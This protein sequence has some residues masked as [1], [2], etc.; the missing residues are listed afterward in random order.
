MRCLHSRYKPDRAMHFLLSFLITLSAFAQPVR[1]QVIPAESEVTYR[2]V[3]FT[4]AWSG[5]S[6]QLSGEV[7]FDPARPEASRVTLSAPVASFNSG[8]RTRDANM[9][10]LFRA[11]EHPNVRFTSERVEVVRWEASPSGG[12]EGQWRVSGMLSIAG[13]ALPHSTLVDVQFRD[14]RFTAQTAFTFS[15]DA[16]AIERPRLLFRAMEDAV[17]M[18]VR[19]TASR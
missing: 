12:M 13:R 3:H 18:N 1:V 4:H 17:Q 9:V 11:S 16:Y 19:L 10:D 5:S 14:G 2:G 7:T 8:N 6:R 15:M